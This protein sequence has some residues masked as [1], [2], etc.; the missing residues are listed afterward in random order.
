MGVQ[1]AIPFIRSPGRGRWGLLGS[2]MVLAMFD[3]CGETTINA[4]L[5]AAR[6]SA[7]PGPPLSGPAGQALP[8][9]IQVQVFGSDDQPLPRAKVTF[10]A[11]NG[12]SGDP[13][14][15]TTDHNGNARSPLT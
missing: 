14:T 4:P 9:P 5:P 15:A 1:V 8:D 3:G 7:V 11:A 12:G 2:A 6:V 10:S 13:A